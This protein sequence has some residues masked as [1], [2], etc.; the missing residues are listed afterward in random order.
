MANDFI[1]N[2]RTPIRRTQAGAITGVGAGNTAQVKIPY[3]VTTNT[4][5]VKCTVAGVAA[6]RAQLEA[7]ITGLKLLVSGVE[8]ESVTAVQHI[9]LE[10]FYNSGCIGDSGY[11]FFNF[12]RLWMENQADQLNPAFGTVN[13]S[14]FVLEIQQAGG[15]AIDGMTLVTDVYPIAEELGAHVVRRRTTIAIAAT[16]IFNYTD[17][18]RLPGESL[19]AVH[20]QTP[21]VA[22]L[23]NIAVV[24]S[25]VRIMDV[26]TDYLTQLYKQA[27][28]GKRTPQAGFVHLDFLSR[29]IGSDVLQTGLLQTGGSL[30]LELTYANA[31]PGSVTFISEYLSTKPTSVTSA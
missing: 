25:D 10:E 17:L 1:S 16:G 21:V 3:G 2:T 30:V 6:T 27:T 22:N 19:L 4:L 14:N 12:Q 31:A 24:A 9:A 28:R 15:S 20:I 26:P 13:E 18:P 7:G 5:A 29:N 8:K 23:T 11:L